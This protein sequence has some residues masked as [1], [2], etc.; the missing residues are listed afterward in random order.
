MRS[1][2]HSL[3]DQRQKSKYSDGDLGVCNV[4]H[5]RYY[6]ESL[7]FLQVLSALGHAVYM[8]AC[9]SIAVSP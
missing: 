6:F 4:R 9:T 1:E 8:Y 5:L 2:I 7:C 3:P